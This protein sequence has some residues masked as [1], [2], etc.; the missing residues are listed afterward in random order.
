MPALCKRIFLMLRLFVR[1]YSISEDLTMNIDIN[2]ANPVAFAGQSETE[3]K[4]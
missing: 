3:I 1:R 4:A 2:K